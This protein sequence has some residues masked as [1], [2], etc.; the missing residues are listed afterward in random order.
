M[1]SIQKTENIEIKKLV[2]RKILHDL[3]EWFGIP[4]NTADYINNSCKMPFWIAYDKKNA[5]GF[6]SIKHTSAFTAEIYVM[7][8][9]KAYH[10]KG[11]G[12]DLFDT[13]YNW[14]KNN[15][16]HF[17]QVKTLDASHSDKHYA[18]TR[19]FYK[20]LGFE[21]LECIPE[22]WGPKNPCLI[23]ITNIL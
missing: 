6:I 5:I 9:L 17:L 14:C 1:I 8:I 11:I 18:S 2:C 13:A 19:H 16:Y 12:R 10:N 3:P 15:K 21:D 4:E 23:L 7:G 22:I 20:S